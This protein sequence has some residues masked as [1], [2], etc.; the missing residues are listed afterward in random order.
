MLG[1][2]IKNPAHRKILRIVMGACVIV[3][4]I[5]YFIVSSTKSEKS[6][7]KKQT[8]ANLK[9]TFHSRSLM[10]QRLGEEVEKTEEMRQKFLKLSQGLLPKTGIPGTLDDITKLAAKQNLKLST[11]KP[12]ALHPAVFYAIIP[13]EISVT[14]KFDDIKSFVTQLNQFEYYTSIDNFTM[15]LIS[16]AGE[17]VNFSFVLSIYSQHE[18]PK[19]I[20]LPKK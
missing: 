20:E 19:K 12:G 16:Q 13:V 14:G 6:I 17:I 2:T 4:I 8:L 7:Q 5:F 10:Y 15:S 11:F 3:L 1:S 9:L 18:E